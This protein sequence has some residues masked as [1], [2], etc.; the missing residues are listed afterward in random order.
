MRQNHSPFSS[1]PTPPEAWQ[2]A[3]VELT[4]GMGTRG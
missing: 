1:V 4:S 2:G 3:G